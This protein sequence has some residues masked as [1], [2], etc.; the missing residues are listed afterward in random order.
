MCESNFL[1]QATHNM[2]VVVAN[3]AANIKTNIQS[4]AASKRHRGSGRTRCNNTSS[5][6][7]KQRLQIGGQT[8][9]PR[10]CRQRHNERSP[11]KTPTN[12]KPG[13]NFNMVVAGDGVNGDGFALLGIRF[14]RLVFDL[15]LYPLA[16]EVS[17]TARW[18]RKK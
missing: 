2:I 16:A 14:E 18:E 4:A 7:N 11:E 9:R 1:E 5:Y 13:V 6:D 3:V 8:E 15:Q 12:N 10:D 17:G